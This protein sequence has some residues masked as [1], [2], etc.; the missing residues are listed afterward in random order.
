MKRRITHLCSLFAL[1]FFTPPVFFAEARSQ[2]QE[3]PLPQAIVDSTHHDFG[4]IFKGEVITHVF[5]ITNIGSA[6]LEVSDTRKL[7][8]LA[9]PALWQKSGLDTFNAA[10]VRANLATP[11]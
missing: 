1:L 9:R 7:I 2:Q 4:N 11:S 5:R 8:G 10:P 6:T 3:K